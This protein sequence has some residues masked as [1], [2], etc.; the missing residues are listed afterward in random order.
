PVNGRSAGLMTLPAAARRHR[1]AG[2]LRRGSPNPAV[3]PQA[4]PNSWHWL[5]QL[6][7]DIK[8]S[9]RSIVRRPGFAAV[10]VLTL[11]LGIGVNTAVFSVVN[12]V[13]L[14]PMP[15]P[16]PERLVW[17][18]DGMTQSDRIGWPACVADFL[19]WP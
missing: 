5:D 1:L 2:M 3:R 4:T 15:Y 7:R 14:R 6:H 19:L 12:G 17:I 8:L 18:H 16:D 13:L 11:A 10:A 9:I